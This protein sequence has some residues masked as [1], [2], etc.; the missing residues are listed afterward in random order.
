MT[1]HHSE[2]R[3]DHD[4]HHGNAH[5][6]HHEAPDEQIAT[7]SAKDKL[8]LRLEHL[9]KHNQDHVDSFGKLI[10]EAEALG[11]AEAGQMILAASAYI[12]RQNDHLV[13][14]LLILR[15]K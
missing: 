4:H 9:L 8:V 14:A 6:Q 5:H 15:S 2:P 12:G 7:L 10:K 11:E 3:C 1:P 13:K